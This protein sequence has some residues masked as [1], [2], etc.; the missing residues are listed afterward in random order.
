MNCPTVRIKATSGSYPYTTI[1]E[2][3]FDPSKHELYAIAVDIPQDAAPDIQDVAAQNSIA[4]DALA[5]THSKRKG[6][7]K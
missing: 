4:A 6:G 5:A 1:N 2:A 3:D 7:A